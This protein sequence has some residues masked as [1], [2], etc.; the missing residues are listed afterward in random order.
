MTGKVIRLVVWFPV[1]AFL[2]LHGAVVG[3]SRSP[4]SQA[5][6]G[7]VLCFPEPHGRQ[8]HITDVRRSQKPASWGCELVQT[9]APPLHVSSV[10]LLSLEASR[11]RST[12]HGL[13]AGCELSSAPGSGKKS[14]KEQGKLAMAGRTFFVAHESKGSHADTSFFFSWDCTAREFLGTSVDT[15]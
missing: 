10:I 9:P 14:S 11:R 7:G 3:D 1:V 2:Y 6:S 4:Y 5:R 13:L 12:R 8:R 15:G